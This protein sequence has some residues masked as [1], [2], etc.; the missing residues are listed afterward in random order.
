MLFTVDMYSLNIMN[1]TFSTLLLCH[2][3]V[4]NT[5][6][7]CVVYLYLVELIACTAWDDMSSLLILSAGPSCVLGFP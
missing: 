5:L 2:V 1:F 4:I 6:R 7:G 3:I